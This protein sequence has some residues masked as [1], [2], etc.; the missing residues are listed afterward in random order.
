[1]SFGYR[2]KIYLNFFPSKKAPLVKMITIGAFL[3][4]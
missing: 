2:K 4:V 1:M 3:L